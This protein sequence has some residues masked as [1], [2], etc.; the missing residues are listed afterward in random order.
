MIHFRKELTGYKIIIKNQNNYINFYFQDLI[1][2]INFFLIINMKFSKK[3][4]F[5]GF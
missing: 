5:I 2:K 4:T 3:K 1:T